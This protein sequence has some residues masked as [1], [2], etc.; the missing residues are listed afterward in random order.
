[1]RCQACNKALS[2]QESVRRF[3][4][5]FT[6]VDLCNGCLATID[7]S[8]ETIDSDNLEDDEYDEE[9]W[10]GIYTMAPVVIVAAGTIVAPMM[11]AALGAG[12]AVIQ[13]VGLSTP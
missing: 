9:Q 7:D 3:K 2:T 13:N 8:V 5:S 6:F 11:M 1:M 12:A 4:E 10:L